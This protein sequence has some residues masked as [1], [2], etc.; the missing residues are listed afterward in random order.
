VV[1]EEPHTAEDRKWLKAMEAQTRSALHQAKAIRVRLTPNSA[2]LTF[3]GSA[4]LTVDQIQKRRSELLTTFG[5]EIIAVQPEAGAITLAIARPTRRVV[6]FQDLWGQWR[7]ESTQGN[8][9]LLIGVREADG[10][11]LV[12]SPGAAHA[13]H[14]LIAG[15]TGSGKSVLMQNIC[16]CIAA[17]NT[18]EQAEIVLID[19]KLGVD[20]FQLE[21]LPHLRDGV[22][23]DQAT[24]LSRLRALVEEMNDRYRRFKEA[25]VPNL[26]AYNTKA[27]AS[28]RLP[29]IWLIHDEFAE[30]MM[31]EEYKAEVISIV[32][33]LG[34]KARAAGIHLVFAAQRPEASV[35]PMQLRANLGNRLILRVDSKGTSEIALGGEKGAEQ[36]L[37]KGHLL[38]K[39]EGTSGL[40]YAQVPYV[41]PETMESF[42]REIAPAGTP[43][44]RRPPPVVIGPEEA[45]RPTQDPARSSRSA[46]AAGGDERRDA[47]DGR[48]RGASP[49]FTR[50]FLAHAAR[51][52]G[53]PEVEGYLAELRASGVHPQ[54][55]KGW[56]DSFLAVR[57]ELQAMAREDDDGEDDDGDPPV[58][59]TGSKL[60]H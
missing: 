54:S 19:P 9:D 32:G 58:G 38:A 60:F 18:V 56:H 24:A 26:R 42:V 22:I 49:D 40:H 28:D 3:A 5:V 7:P 46:G 45:P 20:Y 6:R 31:V 14:T 27:G 29:T 57:K 36:L 23:C 37:G 34:V 47:P 30:W 8:S 15:S 16:L 13:P 43:R 52:W 48:G 25:K 53:A 2:L 39:L 4:N 55:V 21:D 17:T 11:L 44:V 51:R 33:R 50:P 35:M 1:A 10:A 41:D 12:L 59:S